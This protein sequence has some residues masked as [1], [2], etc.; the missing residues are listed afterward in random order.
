MPAAPSTAGRPP[1]SG[2]AVEWLA[3]TADRVQFDQRRARCQCRRDRLCNLPRRAVPGVYA[4]NA[5]ATPPPLAA[6]SLRPALRPKA[7]RHPAAPGPKTPLGDA[8]LGGVSGHARRFRSRSVSGRLSARREDRL[9]RRPRRSS[10]SGAALARTDLQSLPGYGLLQ[11]GPVQ[12]RK[13]RG[14]PVQHLIV[15]SWI[16]CRW[17]SPTARGCRHGS[18]PCRPLHRL[19]V[20]S[21]DLA[22]RLPSVRTLGST[23]LSKIVARRHRL[24]RASHLFCDPRI[25]SGE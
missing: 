5:V 13:A 17:R 10:G 1:R 24:A 12:L 3:D 25:T 16:R 22:M 7:R 23:H 8:V 20:A 21:T 2:P 15:V 19:T 6:V 9:N 18:P 11:L 4:T 14:Q